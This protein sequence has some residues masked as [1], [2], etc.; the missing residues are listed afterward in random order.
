MGNEWIPVVALGEFKSEYI[1]TPL[2]VGK[3][4]Y[5]IRGDLKSKVTQ[6]LIYWVII[7]L[8][9]LNSLLKLEMIN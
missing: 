4:Y 7:A 2:V 9:G 3:I 8:S 1:G 5:I 6:P